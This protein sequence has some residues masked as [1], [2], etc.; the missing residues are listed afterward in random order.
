LH[1]RFP[2]RTAHALEVKMTTMRGL[3]IIALLLAG[4]SPALTQNAPP[5]DG[6]PPPAAGASGNPA[7]YGPPGLGIIPGA[8]GPPYHS[9][10]P[11]PYLQSAALPTVAPSGSRTARNYRRSHRY[12]VIPLRRDYG[13]WPQGQYRWFP[14]GLAR[15]GYWCEPASY[16]HLSCGVGD[17]G[18]H[19]ASVRISLANPM[20]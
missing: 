8:P 4:S 12:I 6:Y 3:A 16:H 18:L 1:S 15:W 19:R 5:A 9:T 13:W 2:A 20:N 11:R 10:A 14:F 17:Y 7:T